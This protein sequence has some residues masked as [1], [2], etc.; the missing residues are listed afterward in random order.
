VVPFRLRDGF[1]VLGLLGF[2]AFLLP[3]VPALPLVIDPGFLLLIFLG[4]QKD[5]P[6]SLWL[7]GAGLGFFKD[8]AGGGLFGAWTVSY[9]LGGWILTY[10]RHLVEWE[11][12]LVQ[13]IAAALLT[14]AAWFLY[15]F[16][17]VTV[18][19]EVGWNRWWWFWW[20]F[21]MGVHGAV[22]YLVFPKLKGI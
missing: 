3:L 12:P 22:A 10:G 8:L 17:A 15:G 2:S 14:G 5:R 9:A 11:D 18:D 13:S 19:P 7:I 1:W 20:P 6:H 21:A 4:F 16:L